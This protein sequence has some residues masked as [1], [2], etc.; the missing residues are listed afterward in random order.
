VYIDEGK[1]LGFRSI[2]YL[3]LFRQANGL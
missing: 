1:K 2:H 3:R